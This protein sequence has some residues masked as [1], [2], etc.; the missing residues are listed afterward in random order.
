MLSC[1]LLQA[2]DNEDL[3]LVLLTFRYD[4]FYSICVVRLLLSYVD[5]FSVTAL[6]AFGKRSVRCSGRVVLF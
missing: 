3:L 1:F 5:Q 6:T 2:S 4:Y